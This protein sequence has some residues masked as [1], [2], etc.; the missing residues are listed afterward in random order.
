M[1]RFSSM[2]YAA[3]ETRRILRD[4]FV[5]YLPVSHSPMVRAPSEN[6]IPDEVLLDLLLN[7]KITF[8][9]DADR[10]RAIYDA[11]L[12]KSPGEPSF[13]QALA[14][15]WF[16]I[17]WGRIATPYEL[18]Q[19][20]RAVPADTMTALQSLLKNRFEETFSMSDT[21]KSDP[22][23]ACLVTRM[24]Q[25]DMT[26]G[27]LRSANPQWVAARLWDRALTAPTPD[28]SE[29]RV[30]IDRWS[31]L[32][33]P[34]L[35]A[36]EIWD[37]TA[38]DAFRKTA[39]GVL[40]SEPGVTGWDETR[41]GF[42]RQISLR[43][44]QPPANAEQH[45]PAVP[46]TLLDRAVWL[47]DLRLEGAIAGMISAYQDFVGL[48]RLLLADV[49][50]Q[51]IASAPHP[52]FKE[53]IE[54]AV[55]R[56][57][58]LAVVLFQVRWSPKLLADLLLDPTTC[59][60]ACWLIAQWPGPSGAW[61]RELR[62]R[63]D[64]TTKVMTFGD[65]VSVLGD[66][67]EN[68]LLPP[69]EAASLLDA[70]YKTARPI[71]S[72]EASEDASILAILRGEIAAQATDVQD[73][74][75]ASLNVSVPQSGL[76]SS[77]FAAALDVVDAADLAASVNPAPLLSAYSGSVAIGAYGLSANRTSVSAAA[78]LVALAMKAPDALRQAFFAPI[79]VRSRIAAAAVPGV[80]PFTIEDETARSVRA[81]VRVL[82]RAVAGLQDSSPHELT[83]AL[84]KAVRVGALKH[85][86]K[87]RVGAFAARFETDPYRGARDRPI[88]V[89]LADALSALSGDQRGKLLAAILEIDE[90]TVLARLTALTPHDVRTHIESRIDALTPADAG[91]IRSLPEAMLRAEELLTAGRADTAARFIEAERGLSTWGP[92]AGRDLAQ[93]RIDLRLKL[94]RHD[95]SGVAATEPPA[96]L[97]GQARDAALDLINFFKGLAALSD[98]NGNRQAAE[99]FFGALH[100]RH[101]HVPAYAINL[102]AAQISVLLG[103]DGFVELQGP[104]RA[105]GRQVLVE[106]EQARF[107]LR[108]M[109]GDDAEAMDCNKGLL[110]LALGQP[111]RAYN[112]LSPRNLGGRP[113]DGAAAYAAIALNRMGRVREALAMLDDATKT[114][115]ETRILKEAREHIKSGKHF[116]ADV[117]LAT[118][119]KLTPLQIKGVLFDL[120]R[121]DHHRQAAILI[122]AS[123]PL[124]SLV[125]E[126]VRAAGE[127][128]ASLVPLTRF[129]KSNL[130][131]DEITALLRMPLAAS[132]R[133]LRW[134]VTYQSPG[135]YS[136]KGNAGKR[137]L[138]IEQ[139]G[140]TVAVIEAVVCRDAMT[141][142]SVQD[143]LTRHFKKLLGYSSGAFFIHLTYSYADDPSSVLSHLQPMVE[144]DAPPAFAYRR[145]REI[146]LTD[147]G[148]TGFVAEYQGPL[149]LVKVVFL[150]LDMR[151]HAQMEA[152]R[153][154]G[155]N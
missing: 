42:I 93:F 109:S 135:G 92:V 129:A 97:V 150:V 99:H 95:W 45:L 43:T 48:I 60:L 136:A 104:K 127:D 89:D 130:Y 57:E 76:G 149:G 33:S 132:V 6:P 151:Q 35:V 112:V 153:I 78:S 111:E 30:W 18:D 19:R 82:C 110:L 41:A 9:S 10:A 107:R 54:L 74:I 91:D 113:R 25:G 13:D 142:R 131:E 80:N 147:S 5:R 79:D 101:P 143:D 53:L 75:F 84:I 65:A 144:K 70:L 108:D 36:H 138:V 69:A 154:A 31:L 2:K 16:R 52:A 51:E 1:S 66:F 49:E 72:D 120:S 4:R 28:A 56:P 40:A 96:G 68:G 116:A 133:F 46:A 126:H 24:E 39:L 26:R 71:F 90:P 100:Q 7:L 22:A 146:P 59:V 115:G 86:E 73:A 119:D 67:L 34:S 140:S 83:E 47:G 38:A 55:T 137:D 17:V 81:H 77:T 155:N 121:M 125:I 63:D 21:A 29:L 106:A 23:L 128:V 37:E 141:Y 123:E 152:A 87:G 3:A 98:P 27:G 8:D 103:S 32:G 50:E 124:E 94:L 64:Q 88:A 122:E 20:A 61:D 44:G 12:T 62:A 15:G 105:R 118:D 14:D 85:D 134:T 102:F 58:I 139:N 148:P 117:S 114:A 11:A 145:S